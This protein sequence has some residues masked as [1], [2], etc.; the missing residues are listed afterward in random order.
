MLLL[1]LNNLGIK[2]IHSIPGYPQQNG[3]AERLNQTI[4]NCAKTLLYSAKLS[5]S[6]WDSAVQC[7]V[8]L[9]N[10]NPHSSINF[11]IPDELFFNKPVDISHF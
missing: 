11:K 6:F 8:F 10:S 9:Y 7:A 3:R 2:F 1:F 5:L 4:N